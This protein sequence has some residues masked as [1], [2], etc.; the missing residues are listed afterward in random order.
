LKPPGNALRSPKIQ[1][2]KVVVVVVEG[3]THRRHKAPEAKAHYG[4]RNYCEEA[5]KTRSQTV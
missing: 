4:G 2:L 1:Y 3:R 5:N